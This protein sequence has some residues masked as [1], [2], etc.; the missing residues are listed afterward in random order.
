V[1]VFNIAVQHFDRDYA[2]HKLVLRFVNNA[3]AAQ[4][5]NGLNDVSVGEGFA[6]ERIVV[7]TAQS[8]TVFRADFQL[9]K[10]PVALRA[11]APVKFNHLGVVVGH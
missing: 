4:S 11:V 8:R 2:I 9:L 3:H 1:I 5:D 6:D 7:L 10:L